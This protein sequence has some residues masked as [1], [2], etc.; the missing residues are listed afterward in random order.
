MIIVPHGSL[1]KEAQKQKWLKK[2]PANI[3]IFNKFID[4]AT[5]IQYLI[6]GEQEKS[7]KCKKYIIAG[8]GIELSD[9]K[10][11]YISDSN[12]ETF[13]IIYIG[14]YDTYTKGLD[15]L[16]KTAIAIKDF[17]RENNIKFMLYGTDYRGRQ[18]KIEKMI[19][20]NNIEDIV[21]M[22]GPIWGIEKNDKMC[23]ADLFIQLSRTEGQPIGLMEAID[24]GL[25]CV[26][27]KATNYGTIIEENNM[28]WVVN[29]EVKD[30]CEKII[31]AYNE[32]KKLYKKSENEKQYAKKNFAWNEIAEKTV[33]KYKEIIK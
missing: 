9:N 16:I 26:V 17:C 18:K 23:K 21:V 10:K 14:R 12:N 11:T 4:N 3:L 28:G 2:I 22:N 27:T 20:K 25:P 24:V 31:E 29:T 13:Q 1:T 6:E 32:R 8:N 5:A 15:L 19:S 33:E 30:I 7:R